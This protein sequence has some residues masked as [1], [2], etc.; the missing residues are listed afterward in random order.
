[1]QEDAP[2]EVQVPALEGMTLEEAS[3]AVKAAGLDC[4]FNGS[5]GM[6]VDQLPAA[7]AAMPEGALVMLYVDNLTDLRD[8]SKVQVPDVTGLSVLEANRMLRS[9]GLK[10][11]IAGSGLAVSQTPAAGEAVFPTATVTVTFEPP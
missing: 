2:E 10:L 3:K 1:V 7:G 8:N 5:G 6:V 4:V 9:Y 11:Q